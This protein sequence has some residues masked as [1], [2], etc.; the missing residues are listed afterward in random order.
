M[1]PRV[2]VIETPEE[3]AAVAHLRGWCH[4]SGE[5]PICKA[6]AAAPPA[7]PAENEEE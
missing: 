6:Y 7:R 2:D 5:C 1:E 3:F 4:D